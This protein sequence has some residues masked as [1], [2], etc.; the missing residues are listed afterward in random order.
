M[1]YVL[2]GLA[3][4]GL[5]TS[6]VFAGIV[7]W[8]VPGYLR[9]RRNAL[10]QLAARPSFTPPLSLFKP[11]RGTDPGLESYL[12]TFFTQD[13]PEYEI[14]FCARDENDP[15]LATAHRVAARHPRISVKFLS[16]GGQPDYIN[17]KVISMEKMEAEAAHGII[18]ISDSD[19]RVSPDYLRAVALPFAD[20]RVGAMCCLYRGVAAEGGLWARL[21]A[22]GM[23]VEMS[24][25]VLAARAMEG[26][27]FTLGPTMAFRRE[28]IRRMGGFRV[29][30]DYCADDF[31][32]GNETFKLGQAV[33][34][35]HHAIDHMVL[36]S[37]FISSLKHQVRWMKST[38]FSRPKGH[39][40]TA[41][42]FSMPFGLLGWAAAAWLGHPWCGL[43]LFALAVAARLA[44]SVAVGRLVVRD[45][46][47]F[48]L[49]IL[50]PIR[51]LMG[52]CIWAASYAGR[53]ILWRGRVYSL[54][55]GGKMRAE[56]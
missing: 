25:G 19:V 50:Y 8:A 51:D 33:A 45:T 52:F 32:L 42:T 34:L 53:R 17:D 7:L 10:V 23:S 11:L 29:T 46:S 38:R 30:A 5:I 15:G 21:E 27:Q 14:L 18:V 16:T 13:Y 24:A 1:P 49:L 12:E 41:L 3:V 56:Q 39:F 35:S 43:A 31:V 37:S 36:N 9:E 55:P 26:M 6:T 54:L 22:V 20:A 4:F 47:W 40:G 2:L 48:G 44:L 28:T